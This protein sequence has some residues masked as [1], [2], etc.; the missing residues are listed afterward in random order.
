[1]PLTTYDVEELDWYFRGRRGE[2]VCPSRDPGLDL[3][4]AAKKFGAA[5]FDAL[6]REWLRRDWHVFWAAQSILV[7]D[8]LQRG[9]GR[10]EFVELP[11][12][13]LQLTPLIGTASGAEKA[14]EAVDNLP[15]A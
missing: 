12:Q 3:P 2:V 8:Q 4:T 10:I 6:Y 11:H 5:R 9:D 14:Q 1:M 15:T 7:R 13:Y